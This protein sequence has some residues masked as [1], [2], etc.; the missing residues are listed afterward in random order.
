VS[1]AAEIFLR[2]TVIELIG[3]VKALAEP[4]MP[5]DSELEA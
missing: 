3:A 2:G 1:G 4:E 5:G